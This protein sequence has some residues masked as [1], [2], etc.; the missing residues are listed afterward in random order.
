MKKAEEERKK[1]QDAI[2]KLDV[3]HYAKE[4]EIVHKALAAE[5]GWAED[6]FDTIRNLRKDDFEEFKRIQKEI[7]DSNREMYSRLGEEAHNAL[8]AEMG[9]DMAEPM[10][11]VLE[12]NIQLME[13]GRRGLYLF[14]D[15]WDYVNKSAEGYQMDV[16]EV[17]LDSFKKMED[18]LVDFAMTGE[19]HFRDFAN[20]VISNLMRIAIQAN[21]TAPLA[22]WV[23]PLL[24]LKVPVQARAYGG[25]VYS[26]IEYIV[27]E[28]GP[29][30]FIPSVP[31]KIVPGASAAGMN[32]KVEVINQTS[33][34]VRAENQP[35][36]F[37]GERYILGV[38]LKGIE[39]NTMGMRDRLG[40]G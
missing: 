2:L 24:G 39:H 23:L 37:D 19:A 10:V 25:P 27:G 28:R 1:M 38:V 9:Y 30:R 6:Y 35:M 7:E 29:E 15:A 32:V 17:F 34:N 8:A 18:A 33:Q 31:G 13:E 4:G 14:A 16:Q 26:G 21:V 5:M 12:R 22:G 40:G 36:R 20:S 3:D 11:S